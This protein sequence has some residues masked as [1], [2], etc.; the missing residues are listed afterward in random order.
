[1][2]A[3]LLAW[4]LAAIF[5]STAAVAEESKG[6]D[7]VPK[8]YLAYAVV[9]EMKE[10]NRTP[11]LFQF[12]EKNSKAAKSLAEFWWVWGVREC[13]PDIAAYSKIQKLADGKY[14]DKAQNKINDYA[15]SCVESFIFDRW[16][17]VQESIK[18][19]MS[20]FSKE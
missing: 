7:G 14:S 10:S 6:Q 15:M 19:K 16:G 13:E 11:L 3:F 2:K 4:S 8:F 18:N 9:H 17:D 12:H 20:N 5:I 1:M